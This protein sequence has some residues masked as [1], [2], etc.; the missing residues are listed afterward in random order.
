MDRRVFLGSLTLL[1]APLAAEAQ[2]ARKSPRVGFVEAGS[3]SANQHFVDAFRAGLRELGYIEGQNITVEE[4]WAEGRIE[5]FPDLLR[6]LLRQKVD[7]IVQASS[8]GA[9]AAKKIT[10]T[11]P[12]VFVGVNDPVGLGLVESLAR[13]GGN[14]TRLSLAFTERFSSQR[15]P[16]D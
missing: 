4:R 5:R 1:V 14:L 16:V 11:V 9:V 12:V 13:P 15:E 8:P 10:A 6:D 3:R 2:P 7:V